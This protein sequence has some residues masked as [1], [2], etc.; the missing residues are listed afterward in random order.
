MGPHAPAALDGSLAFSWLLQLCCTSRQPCSDPARLPA[1]HFRRSSSLRARFI[2]ARACWMWAA[3]AAAR[4]RLRPLLL[5]TAKQFRGMAVRA[6][7]RK[8]QRHRTQRHQR[9]ATQQQQHRQPQRSNSE[10]S[11][12]PP[13]PSMQPRPAQASPGPIAAAA[14]AHRKAGGSSVGGESR[15]SSS[16]SSSPPPG[17]YPSCPAASGPPSSPAAS[18]AA[19]PR[20]GVKGVRLYGEVG[21]R[22]GWDCWAEFGGGK[23]G[24]SGTTVHGGT[25]T[26]PLHR[27]PVPGGSHRDCCL[28][29]ARNWAACVGHATCSGRV[30]G[31]REYQACSERPCK[32]PLL[33]STTVATLSPAAMPCLVL[34]AVV[35]ASRI[36]GACHVVAATIVRAAQGIHTWV[37]SGGCCIVET[38]QQHC[39]AAARL[40]PSAP[41]LLPLVDR[42][43]ASC[44]IH[45]SSP[46][47]HSPTCSCNWGHGSPAWRRGGRS[48][49]TSFGAPA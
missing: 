13:P 24:H 2:T 6:A 27:P 21:G 29:S 41:K 32:R 34:L 36:L 7:Q 1:T 18:A 15:S 40:P 12:C 39:P 23:C 19:P 31:Q 37:C 42:H 14:A 48:A 46:I 49:S 9:A 28:A 10:L 30:S 22:D 20:K 16:P 3:A 25:S 4:P 43:A 5:A 45:C 8:Q 17:V 35:R 47:A 44:L 38:M 33:D 26:E 11:S